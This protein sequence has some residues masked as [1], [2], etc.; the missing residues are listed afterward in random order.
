MTTTLAYLK[1][2]TS[3]EQLATRAAGKSKRLQ[4]AYPTQKNIIM[5][6]QRNSAGQSL[7]EGASRTY[8]ART[9]AC[10]ALLLLLLAGC[11]VEGKSAGDTAIESAQRAA[12]EAEL[13]AI[14]RQHGGNKQLLSE[15]IISRLMLDNLTG[16]DLEAA[17]AASSSPASDELTLVEAPDGTHLM[18]DE[19][20]DSVALEPPVMGL[21]SNE[22]LRVRQLI[23]SQPNYRS[24]GLGAA[25][26]LAYPQ[27][28]GG[29]AASMKRTVNNILQSR[30][31][32]DFGLGK[33]LSDSSGLHRFGDAAISGDSMGRHAGQFGKRPRP[34][35][36]FGL[37]KR[38]NGVS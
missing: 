6:L 13:N 35:Y 18:G 32:Y 15:A 11:L 10:L 20:A 25:N 23:G 7:I 9:G 29:Q 30:N 24:Y 28:P 21:A 37:G 4:F 16:A 8:L 1:T 36:D 38:V 34:N 5:H 19:L 14:I 3:K 22:A 12:L 2:K 33:R 17:A 26:F 27:I 31:P